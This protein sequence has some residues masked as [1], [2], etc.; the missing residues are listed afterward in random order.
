M[1]LITKSEGDS[2]SSCLNMMD[3][4]SP[5]LHLMG[6]YTR[7]PLIAHCKK[8]GLLGSP[9]SLISTFAI[10]ISK[11]SIAK[12]LKIVQSWLGIVGKNKLKLVVTGR[13]WT[14]GSHEPFT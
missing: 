3:R 12:Y 5:F 2:L 7:R 6:K 13:S 4:Q 8:S 1:K 10:S 11:R 9:S 14:H